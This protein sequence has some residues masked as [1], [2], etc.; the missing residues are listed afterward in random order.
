V[1]NSS[2]CATVPTLSV[3]R[4]DQS[5]DGC[6]SASSTSSAQA[7]AIAQSTNP[8]GRAST[9]RGEAHP[10]A[11][12]RC[13][14]TTWTRDGP[15]R[16][17]GASDGLGPSSEVRIAEPDRMHPS[18]GG[19]P[20]VPRPV[21]CRGPLCPARPSDGFERPGGSGRGGVG[22]ALLRLLGLVHGPFR[23][24][25]S[26]AKAT[27]GRWSQHQA[28]DPASVDWKRGGDGRRRTPSGSFIVR[29][30]LLDG[31][32]GAPTIDD[33]VGHLGECLEHVSRARYAIAP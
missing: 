26:S 33:I 21:S 8:T 1:S 27:R 13:R 11:T 4:S 24:S 9:T 19:K 28:A 29:K 15:V 17:D 20:R 25:V 12:L 32:I 7:L 22:G 5:T 23:R 18:S 31:Y 3:N 2:V 6:S 10:P 16:E 30:P 14:V